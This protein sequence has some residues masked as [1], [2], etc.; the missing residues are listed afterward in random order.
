MGKNGPHQKP[1]QQLILFVC[2][3]NPFFMLCLKGN[4]IC[5]CFNNKWHIFSLVFHSLL[6]G[7]LKK[8]KK[9]HTSPKLSQNLDNSHATVWWMGTR[10][11]RYL[12]KFLRYYADLIHSFIQK[13]YILLKSFGVSMILKED[14]L[15]EVLSQ[16]G[17]IYL[18]KRQ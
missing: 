16:P 14:F 1:L 11:T 8:V 13:L 10:A 18:I 12:Q 5:V 15:K 4:K 7:W 9:W 17:C 6:A 3:F 2:C